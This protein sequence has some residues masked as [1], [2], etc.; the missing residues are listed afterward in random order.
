[1]CSVSACDQG[2]V[3]CNG[4]PADGCE[5][6]TTSDIAN[7]GGC[8]KSCSG[9]HAQVK[10]E[11][12]MCVLVACDPGWADCN[13]EVADGCESQL[14]TPTNCASCGDCAAAAKPSQ[15]NTISDTQC[16]NGA[17]WFECF[18][19]GTPAHSFITGCDHSTGANTFACDQYFFDCD[20]NK[21][22][23][24]ETYLGT[25]SNCGACH[26]ICN[27]PWTC[28]FQFGLNYYACMP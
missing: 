7:C 8:G 25:N 3:D 4:A 13:G 16:M 12:G 1:M 26:V 28:K 21:P 22:N 6:D 15:W 18:N 19:M 2:W 17:C 11:S 27:A 23:G 9:A 20:G 10:C 14:G 24:C 5:I